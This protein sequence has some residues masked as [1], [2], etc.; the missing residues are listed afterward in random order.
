VSG[1]Q[2]VEMSEESDQALFERIGGEPAV[3]DLLT[4]FYQRV[5]S[6]PE[7]SRFFAGIPVDKLQRMQREFFAAALGGPIHYSGRPLAHVHAGLG[8]KP[9]DLQRFLDILLE[10]LKEQ[11]LSEQ[12]VYDIISRLNTYSDE[13]TGQASVDG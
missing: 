1:Q 7:L 9:R 10:T 2:G 3:A 13:I 8:I 11:Q 4:A 6:D 5:L 12:D